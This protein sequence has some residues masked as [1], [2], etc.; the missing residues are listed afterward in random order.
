MHTIVIY[1]PHQIFGSSLKK[2]LQDNFQNCA[3]F[4][5]NSSM[6]FLNHLKNH[7]VD[8]AITELLGLSKRDVLDFRMIT[9]KKKALKKIVFSAFH[10]EGADEIKAQL[11]FQTHLDKKISMQYF[12]ETVALALD[13]NFNNN[14]LLNNERAKYALRALS[15]RE[16]EICKLIL[17]GKSNFEICESLGIKNNTVSTIKARIFAKLEVTNTIELYKNYRGHVV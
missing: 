2:L 8:L 10:S 17:D 16:A 4:V 3:V 1:E 13:I 9:K 5:Y 7:P 12:L 14:L 11:N 6:D 15:K